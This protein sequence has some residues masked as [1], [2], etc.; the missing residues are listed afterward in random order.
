[1][2]PL[3][4]GRTPKMKPVAPKRTALV[5]A[6]DVG[7]DKIACL[8][9]RLKPR[10][11]QQVLRRR[12]HSIDVIGFSH[13]EARGMKAGTVVDL[14]QAEEAVRY[15]VHLAERSAKCQVESVIVSMSSGRIASEAP[16]L[17]GPFVDGDLGFPAFVGPQP[18]FGER[19]FLDLPLLPKPH[20]DLKVVQLTGHFE[21]NL[22]L[23]N[24]TP[25]LGAHTGFSRSIGSGIIGTRDAPCNP[26]PIIPSGE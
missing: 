26:F 4:Y 12:S 23:Q 10:G 2:S 17:G 20:L 24:I 18:Q 1:M 22:V 19:L 16:D 5:A 3:N 8:I 25:R 13:T 14:S 15:A 6:V 9:A 7:T 21:G 11:P